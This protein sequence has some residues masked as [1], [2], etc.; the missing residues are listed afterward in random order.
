M[1]IL[2][3][4]GYSGGGIHDRFVLEEGLDFLPKPYSYKQLQA[5]VRQVIDAR[6][7]QI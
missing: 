7:R 2:F 6:A 5:K 1:P 3:S 4:S